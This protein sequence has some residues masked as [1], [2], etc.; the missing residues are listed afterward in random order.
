MA[1]QINKKTQAAS[2]AETQGDSSFISTVKT[3]N[4]TKNNVA[5][6]IPVATI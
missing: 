6:P 3:H 5:E 1:T 2:P 4:R